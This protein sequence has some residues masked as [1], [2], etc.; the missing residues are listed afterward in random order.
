MALYA[1]DTELV[2]SGLHPSYSYV[3]AVAAETVL[4]G[5]WSEGVTVI[6]HEDG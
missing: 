2:L 5:P 6:L 3:C 1:D 4:I